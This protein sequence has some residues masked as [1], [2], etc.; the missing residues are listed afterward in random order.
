MKIYNENRLVSLVT[1]YLGFHYSQTKLSEKTKINYQCRVNNL[2]DFLSENE[3]LA[4]EVKEIGHD[5]IQ[6][7][8][9][10]CNQRFELTNTSRN[11]ELLQNAL[12]Y[13]VS[14]NLITHNPIKLINTERS[15]T[16]E[17]VVLNNLEMEL[18]FNYK[19][20]EKKIAHCFVLQ[21]ETG[22][23]YGDLWETLTIIEDETG[24]WLYNTRIKGRARKP[25]EFWIPLS[26][27]AAVIINH[28]KGKMPFV[29][30]LIYNTTIREIARELGITKYITSHVARKTFATKMYASGYS[31][32]AICDMMGITLFTL[33]KHYIKKTRNRIA[34]ERIKIKV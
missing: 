4:V 12:D 33:Y 19:G 29:P 25:K 34:A 14:R 31:A 24:E 7:F 26:E 3:L 20:Y 32:E 13:A 30:N 6:Q 23:S 10:W 18:F 1:K 28:Y 16:K 15:R 8:Q 22:I 21:I 2:V 5:I 17:I 27:R 11:V 9:D